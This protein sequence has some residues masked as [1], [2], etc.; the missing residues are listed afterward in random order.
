MEFDHI[1]V[2]GLTLDEA[3]RHVQSTL[4]VGLAEGG[5]HA[6]FGTHNRLLG[7]E[8]GLYLEAIA[9]DTDA[10]PPDRPRWF[11]LDRFSGPPR[12]SNWVCRVDDLDAALARLP[13]GAGRPV[14]VSRGALRWRMAVPDDGIL[15]FDG[16]FPALIEWLSGG[17]PA[18]MLP[19][20]GCRLR[21]LV[22]AHPEPEALQEVLMPLLSDPRIR[23]ETGP[24]GAFSAVFE[25]PSGRKVLQ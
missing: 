15:P 8:D 16:T 6:L 14:E 18:E 11:D 9:I 10:P 23:F 22:I 20:S 17:H 13:E 4:G 12:I 3:A 21:R 24:V 7:L 5:R 19:R 2:A 25:T 1:A